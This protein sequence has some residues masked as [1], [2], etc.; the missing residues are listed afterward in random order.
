MDVRRAFCILAMASVV[1]IASLPCLAQS[2]DFAVGPTDRRTTRVRP[3]GFLDFSLKRLNPEN[4][5]YGKCIGEG[6][7]LLIDESLQNGYFWSNVIALGML[8]CQFTIILYQRRV[9]SKREY[10]S[11]EVL[12]QLERSLA[13]SNAEV[14]DVI[15]KNRDLTESFATL[16][17]VIHQTPSGLRDSER[18]ERPQAAQSRTAIAPSSVATT[19][20]TPAPK[21]PSSR[22]SPAPR[23]PSASSQ[24]ALFKPEVELV[25]RVNSL[26]QQLSR[27]HE[28]EMQLRRQLNEA[29]RK[30]QELDKA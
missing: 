15:R 27:S 9:Q 6:R 11:A 21:Q 12:T 7:S 25:N 19:A 5:D 4:T 23:T 1:V 29:D 30:P 16:K 2:G 20:R 13:R 28:I 8:G 24:I 3:D 18:P 26:E 14:E 17:N 22:H 10:S